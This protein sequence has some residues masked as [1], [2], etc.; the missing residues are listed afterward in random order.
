MSWLQQSST[1]GY[2]ILA[3][4]GNTFEPGQKV[5]WVGSRDDLPLTEQGRKQALEIAAMC[6]LSSL[7]ID[8]IIAGPLNR[9]RTYANLIADDLKFAA[10]ISIDDRL[11]ELDYGSWSGLSDQEVICRFGADALSA[12]HQSGEWPNLSDWGSN[13][14]RIAD[15]VNA[16][17]EEVRP[18]LVASRNVLAVT[19]NGRLKFFLRALA[20]D[21]LRFR[22]AGGILKVATGN[23]CLFSLGPSSGSYKCHGWNVAPGA[24]FSQLAHAFDR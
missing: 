16:F 19:S 4:H 20:E 14:A 2:L 3:R 24:A 23:F 12:W 7:K 11:N 22:E 5:V 10:Q 6:R 15:E 1:G 9:T 8:S 17:L 21:F 13:P 18:Q